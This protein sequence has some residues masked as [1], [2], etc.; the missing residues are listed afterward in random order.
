[1]FSTF[2][3][4]DKEPDQLPQ[5][6]YMP[7]KVKTLSEMK[8]YQEPTQS[9]TNPERKPN[10]RIKQSSVLSKYPVE[11]ESPSKGA[12]KKL[13]TNIL[14]AA[15]NELNNQRKFLEDRD[16]KMNF[17]IFKQDEQTNDVTMSMELKNSIKKTINISTT[18]QN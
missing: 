8:I 7:Q 17:K 6:Q 14:K 13:S 9:Q 15:A 3:I 16:K 10:F 4:P 11:N 2:E 12:I 5:L 1:M 18:P